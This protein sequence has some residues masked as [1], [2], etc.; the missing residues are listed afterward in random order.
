MGLRLKTDGALL[1]F[2]GSDAADMFA[3]FT[4]S[5]QEIS[6]NF[7]ETPPWET[8]RPAV[9]KTSSLRMCS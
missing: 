1:I 4:L 9:R 6:A 8:A 5:R 3:G 2:I 7:R